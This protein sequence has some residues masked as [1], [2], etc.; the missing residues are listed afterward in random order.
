MLS[1]PYPYPLSPLQRSPVAFIDSSWKNPKLLT[2]SPE[3]FSVRA[4]S[5]PGVCLTC[6]QGKPE[7]C[8]S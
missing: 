8:N 6:A 5:D 3:P 7:V 4:F 2:S 1:K